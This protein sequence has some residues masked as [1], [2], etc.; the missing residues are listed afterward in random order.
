MATNYPVYPWYLFTDELPED[1]EWKWFDP[2][3]EED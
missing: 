2:E 3:E 1:S